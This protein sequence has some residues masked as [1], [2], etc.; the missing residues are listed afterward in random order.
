MRYAFINANGIVVNLIVGELTEQQQQVF[1]HDY[2]ILFGAT[3]ILSVDSDTT[4]WIGGSYTDGTFIALSAPTE[5]EV[6]SDPLA[7]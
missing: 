2:A 6:P 5:P 4:V 3:Q 1:L 7:D